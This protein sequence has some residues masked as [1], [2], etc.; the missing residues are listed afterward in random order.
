ML[1][2]DDFT[3]SQRNLKYKP[4]V[5]LFLVSN[6]KVKAFQSAFMP[7]GPASTASARQV[8]VH[9]RHL[10]LSVRLA[11]GLP[12]PLFAPFTFTPPGSPFLH[13]Y[14]QGEFS[15]CL[16]AW[17]VCSAYNWSWLPV[18]AEEGTRGLGGQGCGGSRSQRPGKPSARGKHA[19]STPVCPGVLPAC[20]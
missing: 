16:V 18:I 13:S 14:R 8:A 15:V 9:E 4:Y 3:L 5:S 6:V 11:A 12:F 1:L 10:G 7:W 20:N 17:D 2:L 19:P